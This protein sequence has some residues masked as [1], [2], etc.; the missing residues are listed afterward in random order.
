ML[1]VPFE[2]VPSAV[3]TLLPAFLQVLKAAG[4][5][6]FQNA[7]ELHRRCRLNYLD[8]HVAVLLAFFSVTETEKNRTER[9]QGS[10]G[11]VE[12]Q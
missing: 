7:C 3:K 11:D 6:L 5:C 4:E 9:D 2:V 1:P 12:A 8:S 10:T